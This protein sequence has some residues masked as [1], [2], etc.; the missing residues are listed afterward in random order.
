MKPPERSPPQHKVRGLGFWMP[1]LIALLIVGFIMTASYTPLDGYDWL[2]MHSWHKS[3]YQQAWLQWEWAEWN[4]FVSLG[5]PT[6]AE[7]EAAIFYPPSLVFILGP[8]VGLVLGLW[9][10][11]VLV[12]RG[13]LALMRSMNVSGA[14]A[15]FAALAWTLGAP[16]MGRLQ[17]GQ[18]Q[19]VFAL[20]WFPLLL[21][22]ARNLVN[23]P[24]RRTALRLAVVAA[25][26]LLA[27]S[28][29]MA[30]ITGWAALGWTLAWLGL[31]RADTDFRATTIWLVA[32][33]VLTLGLSLVQVWPFLELVG[34]GNRGSGGSAYVLENSMRGQSWWSL[35]RSRPSGSFFYWEYNLY[36][37]GVVCALALFGLIRFRTQ[38]AIGV[39]AAI[40][41]AFVLLALG[42]ATP[43]L[44]LLA[45]AVPGWDSLRFPSRYAIVAMMALV[46]LA[47][48]GV[49]AL[50]QIGT[51]RFRL[52]SFVLG[53]LVAVNAIDSLRAYHERQAAY[54]EGF[55]VA[56]EAELA[57]QLTG[58]PGD[59]DGQPP[60]RVFVPNWL[61][62]SNAGMGMRY[63]A[64]TGF[65]NP[66]IN[67]VWERLH[68][69]GQ[70]EHN[71]RDPVN[72]PAELFVQPL[73]AFRELSL[74]LRWDMTAQK[75]VA[76]VERDARVRLEGGKVR[77]DKFERDE[78]TLTLDALRSGTL[79]IAEPWYPGWTAKVDGV[80]RP[81]ELAQ[82]WMRAI[83][84]PAGASEVSL[85]YRQNGLRLGAFITFISV[86]LTVWYWR[87]P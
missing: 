6:F 28:P 83:A 67:T 81:V 33:G 22:V 3:A 18:I 42:A 20:A 35:L 26:I 46:V 12:I 24:G 84:I 7:I 13:M 52:L 1:E 8:V 56:T 58:L 29:P 40:G 11:L 5:R 71:P 15:W 37:G 44:P 61:V 49:E 87:R 85:T 60:P 25:M 34:Q 77:I 66:T 14:G 30:W 76:P 79:L 31:N 27:G 82:G 57:R 80:N 23:V 86:G 9:G 54:A 4:P 51:G 74:D 38:R 43:I 50:R 62:R 78:I 72:F 59:G 75:F 48:F 41:G 21:V 16:L 17:S 64:V 32:A 45:Q 65:A 73:E 69:L 39:W 36:G 68:A 63:S 70:V 53:A 19:V 10:H 47:G 55:D 2:R